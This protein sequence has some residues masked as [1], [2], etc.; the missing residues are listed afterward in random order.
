[1][2]HHRAHIASVLAERGAWDKRV[3]GVSFDGTGYGDDG[4][5]LGW[6]DFCRQ[7]AGRFRARGSSSRSAALPGGDA[8]A[9]Y[10]VQ[11]AAGFLSQHGRPAGSDWLRRFQFSAPLSSGFS[12]WCATTCELSRRL[13]WEGCLTRRRRCWASPA[14]SPSKDKRRCG[15][16]ALARKSSSEDIYRV[17]FCSAESWIFVHAA[18]R[19]SRIGSAVAISADIA[20]AFQRGIAQGLCDAVKQLVPN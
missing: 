9:Q 14:R 6:R 4:T 3:L 15:S 16:S 17:P 19:C 7:C 5:H 13:R 8:A 10:P 11:A 18:E 1:M 12:D 2:Q 20:R